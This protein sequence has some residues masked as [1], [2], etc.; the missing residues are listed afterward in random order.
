MFKQEFIAI[1]GGPS[2][3]KTTLI[4]AIRR[5]LGKQISIVPEAASLIYRGGFPRIRT[6]NGAVHAQKAI[7]HVQRALENLMATENKEKLIVCDRGSLDG[8][9]YWPSS[10]KDFFK[11]LE[12]TKG[13][14]LKRYGWVI[15]LDTAGNDFYDLSNPLRTE[16]YSEAL[17]LNEKV[18]RAWDGHPK[19]LIIPHNQDFLSKMSF[20]L[21]V[22]HAI[23]DG[24]SYTKIKKKFF[25]G[26][27]G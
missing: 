19:R 15:H 25:K 22:I 17:E 23:L 12:T 2:G 6:T 7:F 9:A 26:N 4:E 20:A 24:D 10:E 14:E 13:K 16:T 3:G 27:H 21:N 1:T 11:I 18:K 8:V 5:D